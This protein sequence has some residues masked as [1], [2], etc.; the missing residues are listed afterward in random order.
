MLTHQCLGFK[1]QVSLLIQPIPIIGIGHLELETPY[2][3]TEDHSR[4]C[5]ED[6]GIPSQLVPSGG[7]FAQKEV[8]VERIMEDSLST[9]AIPPAHGE[10]LK[11]QLVLFIEALFVSRIG[12]G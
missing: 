4:F 5:E 3:F 10:R 8:H 11:S 6:P 9:H 7:E 2:Y 12:L 1:D